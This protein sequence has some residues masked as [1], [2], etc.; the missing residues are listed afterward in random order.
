LVDPD[1]I[2][3]TSIGAYG[4]PET[5]ILNNKSKVV[6]KYIGPLTND[7]ILEIIKIIE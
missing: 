5:F 4:V 1:G 6:R 7:D 3:S 2:I